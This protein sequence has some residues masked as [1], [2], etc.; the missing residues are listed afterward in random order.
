MVTGAFL[1]L[2][3]CGSSS[4]PSPISFPQA[5]FQTLQSKDGVYTVDVYSSPA[6]PPIR[7]VCAFKYDVRFSDGGAPA[8]NL[9][10][11]VVPWMPAMNHGVSIAPTTKALSTPGSYEIDDVYLGMAGEYE[12]ESSIAGTVPDSVAPTFSVN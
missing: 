2:A 12:L 5:P 9:D 11:T 4:A 3:A 1:A 10:V 6:Q 8:P 7:A